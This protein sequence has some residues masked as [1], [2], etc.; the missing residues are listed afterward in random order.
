MNGAG[1]LR[2]AHMAVFDKV[3]CMLEVRFGTASAEQEYA[4]KTAKQGD[5]TLD[6]WAYHVQYWRRALRHR[7]E[8]TEEM[9]ANIFLDGLND[10][11]IAKQTRNSMLNVPLSEYTVQTLLARVRQ[12]HK[13]QLG[14]QQVQT[15]RQVAQSML[16]KSKVAAGRAGGSGGTGSDGASKPAALKRQM[17]ELGKQLDP[18]DPMAPCKLGGRHAQQHTNSACPDQQRAGQQQQRMDMPAGLAAAAAEHYGAAAVPAAAG[19]PQQQA[20]GPRNNAGFN[21]QRQ[22]GFNQPPPQQQRNQAPQQAPPGPPPGPRQAAAVAGGG[23][24]PLRCRTCNLDGGHGAG[25]C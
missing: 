12:C 19:V 4:F 20:P 9:V 8:L 2:S 16:D 11:E 3:L 13:L 10:G 1:E 7:T 22:G 5:R 21:R 18:N 6:G 14:R 23:A 24:A 17:L 25:V 15:D